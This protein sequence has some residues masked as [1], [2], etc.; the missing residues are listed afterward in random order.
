MLKIAQ[1]P[2]FWT[3][4]IISVPGQ[5]PV[6]IK[7]QYAYKNADE[8]KEWFEGLAEKTNLEGLSEIVRDWKDVDTQFTVEALGQLLKAI[9][10][11]VHSFFDCYKREM[12][13]SRV[14]N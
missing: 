14:K 13:E 5:K 8:L 2:T 10:A 6:T 12:L 9:P 4:V 3:D 11:S 7:V 1:D